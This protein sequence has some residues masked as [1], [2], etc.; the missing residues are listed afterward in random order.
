MYSRAGARRGVL[1]PVVQKTQTRAKGIMF[2]S[3]IGSVSLGMCI[4]DL[5]ALLGVYVNHH[6][7]NAAGCAP[8]SIQAGNPCGCPIPTAPG[9]LFLTGPGRYRVRKVAG[10]DDDASRVWGGDRSDR[11]WYPLIGSPTSA[12]VSITR[13]CRS[14]FVELL[15][16]TTRRVKVPRWH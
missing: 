13:W 15:S 12:V 3:T 1:R 9:S 6:R 4:S 7:H 8:M 10:A 16:W 5:P 11:T 2:V 14:L